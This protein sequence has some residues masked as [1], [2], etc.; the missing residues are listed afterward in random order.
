VPGPGSTIAATVRIRWVSGTVPDVEMLVLYCLGL[1]GEAR[2]RMRAVRE[3]NPRTL[4]F[5]DAVAMLDYH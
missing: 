1:V 5:V 3:H 4:S 2:I